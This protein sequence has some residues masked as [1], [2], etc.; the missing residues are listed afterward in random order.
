MFNASRITG[1]Y[2]TTKRK[3]KDGKKRPH[4]RSELLTK[5]GED[6]VTADQLRELSPPE[7]EKPERNG[8]SGGVRITP[9]APEPLNVPGWLEEYG[10]P[11]KRSGPYLGG[12]RWIL[13]ECI[14]QGHTD[15]TAFIIQWPSGGIIAGCSHDSCPSGR[16]EDEGWIQVYASTSS[17]TGSPTRRARTATTPTTDGLPILP[18][19]P[20]NSRI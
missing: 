13:E 17:R 10:V 11:Y 15:N 5:G 19:L 14:W 9:N 18:T 12:Q 7:P 8:R 4:R 1:V 2:G 20:T 3:G 16:A 6:V